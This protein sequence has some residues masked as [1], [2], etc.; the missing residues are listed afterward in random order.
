MRLAAA[1]ALTLAV[2]L[3]LGAVWFAAG[4]WALVNLHGGAG[5]AGRR[6]RAAW[7]RAGLAL[8][9]AAPAALLL[10]ALA[11]VLLRAGD[12]G[13]R[14][15]RIWYTPV[16]FAFAGGW[17]SAG[18][19]LVLDAG[20]REA[21][22]RWRMARRQARLGGSAMLF[23]VLLQLVAVWSDLLFAVPFRR[24]VLGAND[25]ALALALAMLALGLAA[26][27]GLVAGLAGKPRPSGYFAAAFYLAGLAGLAIVAQP[28]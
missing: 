27:I 12:A 14:E 19:Y 21:A 15:T 6:R 24:A 3:L 5:P 20:R 8:A 2:E 17:A 16:P 4:A 23:G 11:A 25:S 1:I 9:Q 22:G 18:C 7:T 13:L 28:G 10:L 26:F